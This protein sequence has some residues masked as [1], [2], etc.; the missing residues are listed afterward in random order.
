MSEPLGRWLRSE[1]EHRAISLAELAQTTRIPLRTLRALEDDRKE[2][3]P[4][5]VFVRGF[6]RSIAKALGIPETEALARHTA[7]RKAAQSDAAP[8]LGTTIS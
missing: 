8:I 5:E 4:G 6:V 3:L 7:S 1:R 2:E